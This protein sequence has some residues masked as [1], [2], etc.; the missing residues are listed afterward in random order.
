MAD[1]HLTAAVSLDADAAQLPP[2]FSRELRRADD[3]SRLAVSAAAAAVA[4]EISSVQDSTGLFVGTAF[5]PLE[6]NFRFLDT[7]ADGGETQ[8]SPTLFSHSVHNAAAGYIAK[9]LDLRGPTLTVTSFAWPFLT[10]LAAGIAAI[11]AGAV[12]RAIVVGADTGSSL[13]EEAS[14]RL[15]DRRSAW[16]YGAAAW[17]LSATAAAPATS[18]RLSVTVEENF[19]D[20][21][22][23][24][25]R[26]QEIWE[27]ITPRPGELSRPMGYAFALTR[28]LRTP[29][30]KGGSI[31][32]KCESPYGR[33]FVSCDG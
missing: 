3:F 31:A 1:A 20:P 15:G 21:I 8:C 7:L 11:A 26:E 30:C 23:F 18:P 10:A 27:G 17:M 13:I 19:C 4:G 24:L 33:V 12:N 28:T 2:A 32:V 25:D 6:T 5:G 14:A 16:R 22:L 9:L 29:L